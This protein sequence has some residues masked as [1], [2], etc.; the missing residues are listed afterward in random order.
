MPK[1][2]LSWSS[3]AIAAHILYRGIK[4]DGYQPEGRHSYSLMLFPNLPVV[5]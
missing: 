4:D 1:L 2:F 5:I 3:V